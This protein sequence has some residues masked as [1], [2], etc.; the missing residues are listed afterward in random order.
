MEE[1]TLKW[2]LKTASP[3]EILEFDNKKNVHKID[4]DII[5]ESN[6]INDIFTIP[7]K[8]INFLCIFE[9]NKIL[10]ELKFHDN[11]TN[12]NLYS[13]ILSKDELQYLTKIIIKTKINK[14]K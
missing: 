12:T 2:S 11:L 3:V 13:G 8:L 9:Q 14:L 6:I 1:K 5:I 4:N 7:F 10:C